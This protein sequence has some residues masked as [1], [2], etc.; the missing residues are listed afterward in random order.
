MK[1]S[2]KTSGAAT[3]RVGPM[4]KFTLFQILTRE[5]EGEREISGSATDIII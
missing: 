1:P 3:A 2:G 4:K 5:R